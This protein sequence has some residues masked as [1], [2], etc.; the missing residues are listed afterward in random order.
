MTPLIG[1]KGF[2]MG[3]LITSL[4]RYDLLFLLNINRP[5]NN[6]TSKKFGKKNT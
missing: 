3:L 1:S 2:I 5:V 4:V 6:K